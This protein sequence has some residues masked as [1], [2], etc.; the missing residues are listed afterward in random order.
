M[1]IKIKKFKNQYL[2]MGS[3]AIPGSYKIDGNNI[4]MLAKYSIYPINQCKNTKDMFKMQ[5]L[6]SKGTKG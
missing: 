4:L 3:S 2:K 5:V 1:N 6:L